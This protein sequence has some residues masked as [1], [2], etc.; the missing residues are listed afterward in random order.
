MKLLRKDEI[1]TNYILIYCPTFQKVINCLILAKHF[2]EVE[3]NE[4]GIN[5]K[6]VIHKISSTL[7][8]SERP[9]VN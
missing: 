2:K 6:L 1:P 8:R 9:F 3:L 7:L 4:R 5:G